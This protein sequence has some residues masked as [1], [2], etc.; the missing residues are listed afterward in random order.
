MMP[1]VAGGVGGMCLWLAIFPFDLIKS[2]IQIENS[3]MSLPKMFVKIV[4]VEGFRTLYRGLTPTLIRTFPATAALL[5]T[6]EKTRLIV[7]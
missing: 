6:I 7:L 2:R 1:I 4:K 3:T 5:F